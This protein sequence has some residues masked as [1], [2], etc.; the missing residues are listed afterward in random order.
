MRQL[1]FLIGVYLLTGCANPNVNPASA[2]ADTGYVDFYTDADDGLNWEVARFDSSSQK[3]T[4]VY[5]EFKPLPDGELRL[6]LSPG[7]H[8]LRVTFLNRV[9]RGPAVLE[10]NVVNGKVTPV[11]VVLTSD[12]VTEVES[13]QRLPTYN[14]Y[15]TFETEI[16]RVTAVAN[17]PLPYRVKSEMP[18]AH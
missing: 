9:V 1:I 7:N 13:K 12:G 8:L 14:L 5:S 4:A 15:N 2:R 3:F 17:S 16:Y 11:H 6:A 18:Y 10:I